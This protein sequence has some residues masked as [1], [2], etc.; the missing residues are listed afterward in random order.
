MS[1]A[2]SIAFVLLFS[3]QAEATFQVS[4]GQM[5]A[6]LSPGRPVREVQVSGLNQHGQPSVWR[7]PGGIGGTFAITSGWWWQGTVRVEFGLGTERRTCLLTGLGQGVPLVLAEVLP[8]GSC[9]A[10]R[11][12]RHRPE[13]N[14]ALERCVRS[15]WALP[16]AALSRL[17]QRQALSRLS[18]RLHAE[19]ERLNRSPDGYAQFWLWLG[20]IPN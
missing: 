20:C 8:D 10:E 12:N 2:R 13:W 14:T 3:G 9:R 19:A 1:K 16:F 5:L 7:G 15:R 17:M 6:L 11:H 4:D 18:N